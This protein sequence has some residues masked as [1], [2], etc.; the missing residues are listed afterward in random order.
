MTY[1]S[2]IL[3]QTSI[4]MMT[5]SLLP[6]HQL[7]QR[8]LETSNRHLPPAVP[9]HLPPPLLQYLL[10]LPCRNLCHRSQLIN[11]HHPS[12]RRHLH[13][14]NPQIRLRND[15]PVDLPKSM[16]NQDHLN[17][18]RLAT[19]LRLTRPLATP[20]NLN[21]AIRTQTMNT[22]KRKFAMNSSQS[23]VSLPEHPPSSQLAKTLHPMRKRSI[24]STV[25]SG[26]LQCKPKWT[27]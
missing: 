19:T 15:A 11:L 1:L 6:S 8:N 20:T 12:L 16:R 4:S 22:M 23:L 26:K 13:L 9:L 14:F 21:S 27:Q 17:V 24:Q 3:P 5:T 10:L 25:T 2:L 7:R 18:S